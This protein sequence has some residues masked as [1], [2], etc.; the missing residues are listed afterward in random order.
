MGTFNPPPISNIEF[1]NSGVGDFEFGEYITL[2]FKY[3]FWI[4]NSGVRQ[5]GSKATQFPSFW[6]PHVI[7]NFGITKSSTLQFSNCPLKFQETGS[8]VYSGSEFQ[9]WKSL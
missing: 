6:I 2:F 5:F 4:L 3:E 7:G 1:E 8:V 9:K